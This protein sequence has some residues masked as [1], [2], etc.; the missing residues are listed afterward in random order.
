MDRALNAENGFYL[1]AYIS[2]N[3]AVLSRICMVEKR[4]RQKGQLIM[5]SKKLT[6]VI[7]T[8]GS[9]S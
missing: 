9:T 8:A 2:I 5:E 6:C 3:Y 1:I 7:K 4:K